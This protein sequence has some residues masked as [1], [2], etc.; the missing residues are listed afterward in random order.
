M[1]TVLYQFQDYALSLMYRYSGP[2]LACMIQPTELVQ[3]GE[4]K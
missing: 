4:L 3:Y 1:F 2:V